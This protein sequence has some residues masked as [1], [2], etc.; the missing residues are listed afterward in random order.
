MAPDEFD[1]LVQAAYGRIPGDFRERL[2][3]VAMLV[4]ASRR[5]RNWRRPALAREQLCW[6]SIRA[7]R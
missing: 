6:A 2:R 5:R 3:N 1:K 7:V 4:E